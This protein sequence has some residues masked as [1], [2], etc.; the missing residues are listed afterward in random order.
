[1]KREE[2]GEGEHKIDNMKL[3]VIIV[4]FLLIPS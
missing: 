1:M 4:H 2:D 3:S